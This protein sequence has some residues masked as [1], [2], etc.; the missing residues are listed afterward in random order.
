[1][2]VDTLRVVKPGES[3]PQFVKRRNPVVGFRCVHLLGRK[4]VAPAQA[5]HKDSLLT[6]DWSK[7]YKSDNMFQET[8]EH[9]TSKSAFQDGIYSEY[10]L[11]NGKLWMNGKVCVPDRLASRI[12]NWWHKWETPHSHGAK[13]W[14]SI[15]HCLFG[16][17]LHT[18]CMKVASSC[19]QCAVAVPATAKPKAI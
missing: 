19:A 2:R 7:E 5:I 9:W 8:Y 12:V 4:P 10:F 1:M 16:A 3:S 11:D 6:K 13:L 15:K 18:H 14:K 17:R